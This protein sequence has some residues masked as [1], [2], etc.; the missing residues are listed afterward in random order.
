MPQYGLGDFIGGWSD[1]QNAKAN[2]ENLLTNAAIRRQ[3]E[4]RLQ[5]VEARAQRGDQRLQEFQSGLQ[6]G[7]SQEQMAAH[8]SKFASP[9]ALMRTQ[10][11]SLDRQSQIE[12]TKESAQSRIQNQLLGLQNQQQ[13]ISDRRDAIVQRT[14]DA[15]TKTNTHY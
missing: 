2:R 15:K 4:S 14:A 6:P 9:E 7:M 3:E 12:A 11:G 8:A 1:F 5:Q 10:Q 13:A